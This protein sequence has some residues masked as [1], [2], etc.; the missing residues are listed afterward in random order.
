[1]LLEE[2][3]MII[4][5][6]TTA[7][8]LLFSAGAIAEGMVKEGMT[9]ATQLQEDFVALDEDANGKLSQTELSQNPELAADF[10]EIDLNQNNDIDLSEFVIYK[11]EATAAGIHD[12]EYEQ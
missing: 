7:F 6:A 2:H 5:I 4:R 11:S 3:I 1:M 10:F 8:I 9:S 12:G